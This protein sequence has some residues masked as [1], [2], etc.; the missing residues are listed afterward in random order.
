MKRPATLIALVLLILSSFPT[1]ALDLNP[2]P[3]PQPPIGVIFSDCSD[4]YI[5]AAIA[6]PD[7]T[8]TVTG[9]VDGRV[10]FTVSSGLN[11]GG[12]EWDLGPGENFETGEATV[13]LGPTGQVFC[14]SVVAP[15]PGELE[16]E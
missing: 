13:S 4:V 9:V 6:G 16:L 11:P 2:V 15:F 5:G 3:I 8:V 10:L 1:Y 14:L 7:V 12:V